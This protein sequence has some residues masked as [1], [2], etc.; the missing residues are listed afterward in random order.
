MYSCGLPFSFRFGLFHSQ[1]RYSSNS[2]FDHN[3]KVKS[4]YHNRSNSDI[5]IYI[6]VF[7]R[8]MSLPRKSLPPYMIPVFLIWVALCN[9]GVIVTSIVLYRNNIT[10]FGSRPGLNLGIVLAIN[11]VSILMLYPLLNMDP[12]K[13][14]LIPALIWFVVVSVVYVILGLYWVLIFGTVQ[15]AADLW[16]E[17]MLRKTAR[18]TQSSSPAKI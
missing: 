13:P 11:I 8:D 9:V 5:F 18:A 2:E 15:L 1:R 3:L 12:I 14:F 17:F 4:Q 7:S 16:F 6:D 10:L